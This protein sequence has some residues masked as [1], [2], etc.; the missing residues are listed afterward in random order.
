MAHTSY[1]IRQRRWLL[2]YCCVI[3]VLPFSPAHA[4]TVPS[5]ANPSLI[6]QRFEKKP[7]A[8]S[9]VNDTVTA[10]LAESKLPKDLEQQMASTHFVLTRV[11]I[12][13]ASAYTPEQLQFA[14]DGMIG[15]K[16]SMIDAH[17][18]ARR[19]TRHYRDHSYL[20]SQ[21][22][23][24]PQTITNGT[25]VIR[26]V[27]G[28]VANVR[29]SS[30]AISTGQQRVLSA[31]GQRLTSVR[32]VGIDDLERYVLLVNDL[33]GIAAANAIQVSPTAFGAVD[34]TT[35]A[36]HTPWSGYVTADNRGSKYVGPLQYTASLTANSLFG[37]YDRTQ[38][39]AITTSP[40]SE[41]RFVDLAHD[42]PL[43]DNGA[44]WGLSGSYSDTDPGDS[45][46]SSFIRGNSTFVQGKIS[47]PFIRTRH[48]NFSGR[49]L[50]DIRNTNT[51]VSGNAF[52]KDRLRSLRLGGSYDFVDEWMGVDLI[53]VQV[54]RGLNV[55]NASDSG[56]LRSRAD[57]ESD[58]T[59]WGVNL[60]RTQSLPNN[61][62]F[63]TTATGQYTA[64]R[65]LAGEQFT[66]GGSG[67]GSAY[68]PSELA[69]DYGA[70]AKAELRYNHILNYAY[71]YSYQAYGY[72]D[73]G[74]IWM[75]DAGVDAKSLSS[76]GI[77]VRTAFTRALS[78]SVEAALPLT[79][80]VS[81]QGN[82]GDDA[83]VFFS[84][85]GRF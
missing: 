11:L 12:E 46:K 10:P 6:E 69:G 41:L 68:D 57:G 65:L 76:A 19:I 73:I 59:K 5:S 25:L 30:D 24:P 82:H 42:E 17:E 39:R 15:K 75:N 51:D 77:G 20:L 83:R 78:G 85:S 32:P 60:A 37:R 80:P 72:Y 34:M 26:V 49:L 27:E 54:S 52:S 23:I 33:P 2:L 50:A 81:N 64:N 28:Y 38:L 63:A 67:F 44:R 21:A 31:Y 79:R 22:S 13:G 45:L 7:T 84:L 1:R 47:Y 71:L 61:F 66:V 4:Q 56:I 8:A 9:S 35:T 14:Y 29:L 74:H 43:G 62:S 58:Y 40:T 55:W 48:E 36:T 18:I 53:D 70:A 16:I 3:V